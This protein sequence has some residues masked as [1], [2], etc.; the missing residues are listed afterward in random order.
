MSAS[1]RHG[2]ARPG[3][4]VSSSGR[5]RTPGTGTGVSASGRHGPA[6]MGIAGWPPGRPGSRRLCPVG[7]RALSGGASRPPLVCAK[8]PPAPAGRFLA[9][10]F[11][12]GPGEGP[13]AAPAVAGPATPAGGPR[14]MAPAWPP[15]SAGR[16]AWPGWGWASC[17]VLRAGA[18]APAPPKISCRCGSTPAASS[19]AASALIPIEMSMTS[20]LPE[21]TPDTSTPIAAATRTALDLI[22]YALTWPGTA[23]PA[24]RQHLHRGHPA[25]HGGVV[26]R[27]APV[28]P[29]RRSRTLLA[30]EA[31]RESP[32]ASLPAPPQL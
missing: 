20:R 16:P 14:R 17:P 27:L 23:R 3:T 13:A 25:P 4:G 15:A 2:P 8:P 19:T 6:G 26:R 1:G 24:A 21:K 5:H 9:L 31:T 18:A 12:R 30:P 28:P 11:G 22:T 7:G 10:P 29:L 32:I